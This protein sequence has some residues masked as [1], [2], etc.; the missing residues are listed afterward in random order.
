MSTLFEGV[1]KQHCKHC[2]QAKES[3]G[4]HEPS[5]LEDKCGSGALAETVPDP[6]E[7][8]AQARHHLPKAV[9]Y[10]PIPD[11]VRDSM[12]GHLLSVLPAAPEPEAR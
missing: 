5:S 4:V 7:G 11:P 3:E 1:T 8:K 2:E 10:A 9:T 12:S 6:P